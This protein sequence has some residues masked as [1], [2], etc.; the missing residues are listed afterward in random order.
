MRIMKNKGFTL[1]ELLVVI[2]IIGLLSSIVLASLGTARNKA[3]DAAIMADL[4]GIRSA[5]EIYFGDNGDSYGSDLSDDCSLS[6][7]VF[8]DSSVRAAIDH[9]KA[10]SGINSGNYRPY[11]Y[12]DTTAGTNYAVAIPLKTQPNAD[13][14]YFCVDSSG[15]AR[16]VTDVDPNDGDG[17]IINYIMPFVCIP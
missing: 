12:I 16:I 5:A 10:Q 2:A 1:I 6:V 17:P 14:E 11:C 7:G 3:A 15:T 13:Y 4:T 9:A 8:S